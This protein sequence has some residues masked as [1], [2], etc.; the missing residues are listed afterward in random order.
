MIFHLLLICPLRHHCTLLPATDMMKLS[1]RYC[2]TVQT[3]LWRRS[4]MSGGCMFGNIW[5]LFD[6]FNIMTELQRFVCRFTLHS[7]SFWCIFQ[8]S[9]FIFTHINLIAKIFV[10][11]PHPHS[12]YGVGSLKGK[13]WFLSVSLNDYWQ[14]S[15]W[16]ILLCNVVNLPDT[17]RLCLWIWQRDYCPNHWCLCP[18]YWVEYLTSDVFIFI[19]FKMDIF[20]FVHQTF[21]LPLS[22]PPFW[23]WVLSSSFIFLLLGGG[24]QGTWLPLT[25]LDLT[26]FWL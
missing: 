19:S 16:S 3:Q 22:I 20:H 1:W 4:V 2:N 14:N 7:L 26:W 24:H 17:H 8:F 15:F 10:L 5:L 25:H 9:L 6:G 21:A 11:L 23:R 18:G 12:V 13:V